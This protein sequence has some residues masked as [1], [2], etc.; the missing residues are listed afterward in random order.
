MRNGTKLVIGLLAL[1][2]ALAIGLRFYLSSFENGSNILQQQG[3]AAARIGIDLSQEGRK[4]LPQEEQNE[5]DSIYNEA[6][7]SLRQ[8]ERQRFFSLAQKGAGAEE[9]EL[10]ESW[11]LMQKALVT[12]PQ[13]RRDRLFALIDKAVQLAQR[14]KAVSEKKPEGQ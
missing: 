10:N 4:L 1:A 2:M 6:L 13:G 11:M 7:Q 12:L 14:K 5:L 8:E 3:I 9:Q